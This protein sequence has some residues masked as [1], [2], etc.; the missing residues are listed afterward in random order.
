M[1]MIFN[2]RLRP[3][4]DRALFREQTARRIDDGMRKKSVKPIHVVIIE[5]VV[6]FMWRERT[7]A[8]VAASIRRARG[9]T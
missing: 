4:S 9:R 7:T 2:M 3:G 1:R 5:R 6:A 8:G